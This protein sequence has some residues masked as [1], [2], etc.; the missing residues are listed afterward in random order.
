MLTCV[1]SLIN[2]RGRQKNGIPL[3]VIKVK[4]YVNSFLDHTCVPVRISIKN[5]VKFIDRTVSIYIPRDYIVRQTIM[6]FIFAFFKMNNNLFLDRELSVYNCNLQQLRQS[7]KRIIKRKL[8]TRT[9]CF[10]IRKTL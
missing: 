2:H 6:Y 3:D 7:N 8:L 10:Q 5:E 9:T 1:C 4:C